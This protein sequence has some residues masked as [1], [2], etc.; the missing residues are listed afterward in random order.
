MTHTTSSEAQREE[1]TRLRDAVSCV[2]VLEREGFRLDREA[3]ASRAAKTLKYRR[4]KGE[5]VLVNHGGKGWWSPADSAARGDV[6]KLLQFLH[7]GL[8]LGHVRK[9]LRDMVGMSP[10]YEVEERTRDAPTNTTRDPVAMWNRRKT[11]VKGS[12]GWRYLVETRGLP[13]KVV[14]IAAGQG[15]LREGPGGTVWFAHTDNVGRHSGM[16]MR[17]PSYRGFSTGGIG[18]RLFRF[19]LSSSESLFSRVVITEAAIDAL[20]FAAMDRFYADTLYVSTAGGM[21]PDSEAE[22][23][24]LLHELSGRENARLVIAV[25]HDEQGDRYTE[26]FTAMAAQVGLWSGRWSPAERGHDWNTVLRARGAGET[27]A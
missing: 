21:S 12:A 24:D 25:D 27:Q 8:T 13:E 10:S 1:L 6:F 9:E 23:T 19:R 16:E 4:G 26:K 17:G 5:I 15:V 14:A 2:V 22:L 18:K 3:T 11:P 20:S 7:P